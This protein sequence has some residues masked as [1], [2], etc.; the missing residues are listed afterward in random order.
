MFLL[1]ANDKH[2]HLMPLLCVHNAAL[3]KL[4]L[5]HG[6]IFQ[7]VSVVDFLL[8]GFFQCLRMRPCFFPLLLLLP[9]ALGTT[10]PPQ[11]SRSCELATLTSKDPVEFH[12][13]PD[14]RDGRYPVPFSFSVDADVAALQIY[15]GTGDF[16]D[17]EQFYVINLARTV[18][19]EKVTGEGSDERKT[20]ERSQ[21]RALPAPGMWRSYYFRLKVR[22]EY[23]LVGLYEAGEEGSEALV[24]YKDMAPPKEPFTH[25][26]FAVSAKSGVK[27]RASV[28]LKQHCKAEM[29]ARCV[30]TSECSVHGT[31]CL[32][33]GLEATCDCDEEHIRS[34]AGNHCRTNPIKIGEVC[35]NSKQCAKL[36][37]KCRRRKGSRRRVCTCLKTHFVDADGMC[38]EVKDKGELDFKR[39]FREPTWRE[40][41]PGR[42]RVR[43]E[44]MVEGQRFSTHRINNG[45]G[46]KI[47]PHCDVQVN[48]DGAKDFPE[49]QLPRE[50]FP[51]QLTKTGFELGFFISGKGQ[52][53]LQITHFG[54]IMTDNPVVF[55]LSVSESSIEL[56]SGSNKVLSKAPTNFNDKIEPKSLWLELFCESPSES[57]RC[58]FTAGTFAGKRP[59]ID[60]S[61][62]NPWSSNHHAT[63][64]TEPTHFAA[65][66][67][68]A[69][70][71]MSLSSLCTAG[72][73]QPCSHKSD[74]TKQNKDLECDKGECQCGGRMRWDEFK[75]SCA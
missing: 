70:T 63:L 12:P 39:L 59:L 62:A 6:V 4:L 37:A 19:I 3:S 60:A 56:K 13:L 49:P 15:V 66:P 51:L 10:S 1:C 25:Y 40:L 38:A 23:I 34:V 52:V 41:N 5:Q 45:T 7:S 22:Q 72:R 28:S 21:A 75:Q 64:R 42:R 61:V 26:G 53:N 20:L 2:V 57:D 71:K 35:V 27:S 18:T 55:E 30:H 16:L 46:G 68:S 50:Y 47:E 8:K 17:D 69:E 31:I 14:S 36:E 67:G 48:V 29:G 33:R 65:V 44:T 54:D 58:R 32:P 43:L 9:C 73:G 74:C 24:S 11:P